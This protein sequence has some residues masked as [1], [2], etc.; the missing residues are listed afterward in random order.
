LRVHPVPDTARFDADAG[1]GVTAAARGTI[2]IGR[3]LD[4]A[5]A[6]RHTDLRW[7]AKG[8]RA[9]RVV[10]AEPSDRG[11]RRRATRA[12]TARGSTGVRSAVGGATGLAPT[13][14]RSTV[15]GSTGLAS[16]HAGT[17]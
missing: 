4:G 12:S 11:N 3:A 13:G 6:V 2:G 10:L 8:G 9:V 17:A 14:A 1:V 5:Q 16:A 7:D 15:G